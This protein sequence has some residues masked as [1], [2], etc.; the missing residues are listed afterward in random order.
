MRYRLIG[1][2]GMNFLKNTSK[3]L[4]LPKEAYKRDVDLAPMIED[5]RHGN[6]PETYRTYPT[7]ALAKIDTTRKSFLHPQTGL[8]M[9][10]LSDE[11]MQAARDLRA[12]AGAYA[13]IIANEAWKDVDFKRIREESVQGN[14]EARQSDETLRTYSYRMFKQATMVATS[15]MRNGSIPYGKEIVDR[16]DAISLMS[17]KL[18]SMEIV[19]DMAYSYV[20]NGEG[21]ATDVTWGLMDMIDHLGKKWRW[22]SGRRSPGEIALMK[23]SSLQHIGA[24]LSRLNVNHA[25]PVL[26]DIFA[27][28]GIQPKYF[29]MRRRNNKWELQ[30][31]HKRFMQVY[32]K[33]GTEAPKYEKFGSTMWC[34]VNY[35]V[36]EDGQIMTEYFEW[37]M[38]LS[39]LPAEVRGKNWQ[40]GSVNAGRLL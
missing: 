12:E 9:S 5:I 6:F 29:N 26:N 19:D 31:N 40:R 14:F 16:L 17:A 10:R 15:K 37:I 27:M 7:D 28:E 3:P 23:K 1:D 4:N 22:L 39:M 21:T 30:F 38:K 18:K 32:A 25:E 36:G 2:M 35:G 8:M 11:S 34:P 13:A 20:E 33:P 24:L